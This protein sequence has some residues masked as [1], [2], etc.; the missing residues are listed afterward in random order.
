M[1]PYHDYGTTTATSCPA[2]SITFTN[3]TSATDLG[4][5]IYTP[6]N[7]EF[8]NNQQTEFGQIY[9]GGAVKVSDNFAMTFQPI[10]VPGGAVSG[11]NATGYSVALEYKRE[12]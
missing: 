2:G 10:L 11:G 4:V 3:K 9:G 12:G 7:V 1:V 5:F 8:T 6:C